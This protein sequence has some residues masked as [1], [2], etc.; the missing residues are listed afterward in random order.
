[1]TAQYI[2]VQQDAPRAAASPS[3]G[4]LTWRASRPTMRLMDRLSFRERWKL[5]LGHQ[6]VDRPPMDLNA[7]DM[8]GIDGGPRRLAPALGLPRG[9]R[10]DD[11]LDEEVLRCLDIDIRCVGGILSPSGGL[12]RQVSDMEMVDAWGITYRWNGHHFE[13]VGRPL[14]GATLADLES[15]PWPDAAKIDRQAIASIGERARWLFESTPWVVCAR[16]PSFGVLELGCWMCGFDDFLLRLAAEPEF[17]HRFFSI[18]REYQRRVDEMYFGAVGRWI[19]FTT[20]GDDFGAQTSPFMSESMFGSQ[21]VPFLADRIGDIRRYT[22]A[23]FFHHT[24]GAI[25]PLIPA[26]IEAGVVILN[27]LQPRAAG[28]EPAGLKADF[29]DK[30]VFY[31][32]VDTQELLPRGTP[33][34]VA[35]ETRRLAGVLGKQGGYVLSAA[36]T[37]QEDVPAQNIVAMYRAVASLPVQADLPRLTC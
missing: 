28:M 18:V 20:S 9:G 12:A 21:V 10:T 35:A 31:G 15:Y 17:V 25:R 5:C 1:M 6:Q 19:H 14:P 7:T 4:P 13:A 30:L 22:D 16:H 33:E 27:P 36:H 23:A 26:L 29:G 37:L 34:R 24:C 8:T 11:E 2:T 3:A 32:G